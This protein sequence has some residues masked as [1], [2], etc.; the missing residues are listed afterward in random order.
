MDCIMK[1]VSLYT[2]R[3]PNQQGVVDYP[4]EENIIWEQLYSR[5]IQVVEG[6]ACSEFMQG[7]HLIDLP[8]DR[9]PQLP[10]ISR[11]LYECTGWEVSPVEALISFDKFFHLLAN[12]QFPVATFIRHIEDLDYL[13]EPD[14]FH[15]TFGHCPL[16]TNQAFADFTQEIG[17]IGLLSNKV[18]QSVLARLY[19]FTVEFGLIE[20]AAGL[21][22]YG[23]GILSS[24]EETLYALESTTP[25]RQALDL[26][27][28]L[29][30]PYHYDEKQMNYFII[31]SFEQLYELTQLDLLAEIDLALTQGMLPDPHKT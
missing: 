25:N 13:K 7:I 11:K 4:A 28:M 8:H 19:W 15:E 23:G 2:A 3:K 22:I 1:K 29:R 6:R 26:Q 17:R 27:T 30:M 14:V 20:N 12:K 21:R 18:Q 31:K 9:I 24:K 10:N 16:L 5:Q